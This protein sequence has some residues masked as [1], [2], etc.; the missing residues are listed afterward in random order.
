MRDR[1]INQREREKRLSIV[2]CIVWAAVALAAFV[3][4]VLEVCSC[5]PA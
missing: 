3:A 5:Q 4:I 2:I 1:N